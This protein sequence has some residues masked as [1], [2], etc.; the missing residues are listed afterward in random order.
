[1]K[2]IATVIFVTLLAIKLSAAADEYQ[3]DPLHSFVIFRC[4]NLAQA[5]SV[6]V[7]GRFNEV[8]GTIIVDKDPTKSSV[9]ITINAESL[10]TGV[11]D[12]DS[13]LKSPDFLNVKRFPTITFKNS[14]VQPIGKNRFQVIGNL[15]LHSVTKPITFVV[16][17]VGEG[18]NFE[19]M[20]VIGFQSSFKI[21]R[22]DFGMKGMLNV[23]A[24]EIELTVAIMGVKMQSVRKAP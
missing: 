7:Y 21:K 14:K 2:R 18:N 22:S 3:I 1:M 16:E 6:Y 13:H 4:K 19:G 8:K 23:A 17:K 20:Q 11:P 5:G 15:T 24:D 9:E 10:D 12:R